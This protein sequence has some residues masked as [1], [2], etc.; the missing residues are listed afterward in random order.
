MNLGFLAEGVKIPRRKFAAVLLLNSGTLAWFFLVIIYLPFIPAST[1]MFGI[2]FEYTYTAGLAV[3]LGFAIFSSILGSFIGGR[4]NRRKLLIFS[5]AL[6]VFST[7]LLAILQGTVF[8]SISALLMGMSLGLGLPSSMGLI[9]DYTVVEERARIS[10]TIILCTFILAFVSMAAIKMLN[11]EVMGQ[12]LLFAVIRSIGFISLVIDKG[13]GQEQKAIGKPRLPDSAYKQLLLYLFPWVIFAI[14]SSLAWSL[15]PP[16]Y[17]DVANNAQTYRYA[18]IA[19]FGLVSGLVADR[20]GRKQPIIFGLVVLATCF[21]VLGFFGIS[22]TNLTIYLALSGIAW[23]SFFVLFLAVPG[24]LSV[25][26][27]REK[28]YGLGYI[29][30]IAVMFAF[31]AM[32]GYNLFPPES[33]SSIAQIFFVLIIF[34]IIPVLRAKETLPEE[35]RKDRELRE[36]L[37]RVGEIVS[38]S[39]KNQ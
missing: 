16:A 5:V 23:G 11:L 19:V 10:G 34:S 33:A 17:S 20:F 29:L 14:I 24:D 28:F 4:V 38:E 26:G 15:V 25:V 18:F 6:G 13:S 36:H 7:V 32:P 9:A 1:T 3:F 21:F 27:V 22:E 35:K 31:A 30:P 12:I 39:D 37:K 8:A 2:S